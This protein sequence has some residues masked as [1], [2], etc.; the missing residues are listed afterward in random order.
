MFNKPISKLKLDV[1]N[2]EEISKLKM[3]NEEGSTDVVLNINDKGNT[4]SFK[5]KN[6]RK[7]D[8][9]SLNLIKKAGFSSQIN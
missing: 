6:K 7:I 4:A 3:I 1:Y 9:N 8:R 5:L 2:I